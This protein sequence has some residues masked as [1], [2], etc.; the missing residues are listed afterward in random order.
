MTSGLKEKV[1]KLDTRWPQ[2]LFANLLFT[3]NIFTSIFLIVPSHYTWSTISLTSSTFRPITKRNPTKYPYTFH[4]IEFFLC[5]PNPNWGA[6]S[7][8]N[9][10]LLIHLWPIYIKGH[11]IVKIIIGSQIDPAPIVGS[12]EPFIHLTH[13]PC[14]G[15][16]KLIS[17]PSST[18]T[19]FP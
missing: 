10:F 12:R 19:L 9:T 6:W 3:Y 16:I 5:L 2:C 18:G 17:L 8:I 1:N 11:P 7:R 4:M 14:S 15:L 13:I